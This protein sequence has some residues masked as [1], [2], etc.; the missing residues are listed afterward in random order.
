VIL[1]GNMIFTDQLATCPA[2]LPCRPRFL[3]CSDVPGFTAFVVEV[4]QQFDSLLNLVD[5][6]RRAASRDVPKPRA[7][8]AENADHSKLR[9]RV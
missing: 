1:V 8:P 2:R 7:E 4:A 6:R 5:S 3:D 9:V